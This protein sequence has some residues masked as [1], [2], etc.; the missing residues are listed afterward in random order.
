M[1][2]QYRLKTHM[3]SPGIGG[4]SLHNPGDVLTEQQIKDVGW[5]AADLVKRGAL[6]AYRA[7]DEGDDDGRVGDEA[8][9]ERI[10]QAI[11]DETVRLGRPL[12]E[13]E[14]NKVAAE[15]TRESAEQTKDATRQAAKDQRQEN[16]AAAKRDATQ[17]PKQQK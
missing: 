11:R 3:G 7:A 14:K 8:N 6:E 10:E 13:H 1:A 17:P 16:A 15:V 2:K 4:T 12:E 9:K 5:D